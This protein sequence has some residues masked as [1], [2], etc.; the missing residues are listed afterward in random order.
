MRQSMD[1]D[2][3]TVMFKC[4]DTLSSSAKDCESLSS[5]WLGKF[6]LRSYIISVAV[7]AERLLEGYCLFLLR[8]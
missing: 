7:L 5:L 4:S 2:E 3:S 8:S 6:Y 1:T